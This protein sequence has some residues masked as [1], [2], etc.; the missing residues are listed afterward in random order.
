MLLHY[1]TLSLRTLRRAPFLT[2]TK[3]LV[4][5]LGLCCFVVAYALVSYWRHAE[6]GFAKADR[7]YATTTRIQLSDG[8]DT[9][10]PRLDNNF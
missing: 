10:S 1:L 3:L 8:S 5:T 7:T 9:T 2:L 6:R 4:L